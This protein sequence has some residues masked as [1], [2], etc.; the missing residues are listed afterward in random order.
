MAHNAEAQYPRGI[1]TGNF[2]ASATLTVA[3]AG[4]PVRVSFIIVT[5]MS[6]GTHI[7]EYQDGSGNTIGVTRPAP[8]NSSFLD[9]GLITDGLIL[10]DQTGIDA[11]KHV[12]VVYFDE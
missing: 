7:I 3:A 9:L 5:N 2:S 6:G 10:E 1:Y 4:T 8:G 11:N 12:M